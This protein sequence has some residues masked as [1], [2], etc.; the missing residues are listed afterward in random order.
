[1]PNYINVK[2]KAQI[3]DKRMEKYENSKNKKTGMV[4][5]K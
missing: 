2:Y 5:L 3:K 4:T 1:M